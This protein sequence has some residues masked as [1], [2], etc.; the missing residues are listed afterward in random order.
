VPWLDQQG[1]LSAH[2]IAASKL[3]P[4]CPPADYWMRIPHVP[5]FLWGLH[6]GP[7][8]APAEFREGANT[9]DR[10]PR[11]ENLIAARDQADAL[12]NESVALKKWCVPPG[13]LVEIPIGPFTHCQVWEL[14]P[15]LNYFVRL[16][17]GDGEF[18]LAWLEPDKHAFGLHCV[19]NRLRAKGLSDSERQR[20]EEADEGIRLVLSA[21][22]RDFC[23]VEER[24]RVFASRS[25]GRLSPLIRR[26]VPSAR[27]VYLPRVK[28]IAPPNTSRCASELETQVRLPHHVTG[29]LRRAETASY[30]QLILARR[31]G[32]PVP[33]GFTF[34]RP[35]QRGAGAAE[36]RYRSRSALRS[37]YTV[38][39]S[40]V[41]RPPIDD[42]FQFERDVYS[43][44]EHL[45]FSVRHVA[46]T[47]RGD[48]GV[49]VF[50]TKGLDLEEVN[51]VIQ[52]KAYGQGRK[53]GPN[54]VRELI[55]TLQEY[56]AGTRGMIVTTSSYSYDCRQLAD[57]H[58]I[59]LI[60]GAEF[61][62]LAQNTG[63]A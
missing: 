13:A 26:T 48:R 14:G 17:T 54:V 56:P 25:A 9:W 8:D 36:V 35:H 34:V 10:M 19:A 31:Y 43:V 24:E 37:L 47:G 53:V 59:R 4:T 33:K 49:D 3:P 39:D 22:V 52:C 23:V 41:S 12:E 6:L 1:Q 58:R 60:D 21:V 42:W 5:E 7:G 63:V 44:M 32:V 15:P 45:G 30:A 46:A 61:A 55:G 11:C 62:A 16:W 40:S 57:A 51:W 28:Y 20:V 27:I 29:H 2:R 50:A 18:D 38:D